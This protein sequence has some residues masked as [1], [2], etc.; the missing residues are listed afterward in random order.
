MEVPALTDLLPTL[1][2]A[3]TK[4]SRRLL[5]R[6]IAWG[7]ALPLVAACSP[8]TP[9]PAATRAPTRSAQAASPAASPA[10]KPSPAAGQV[11]TV[12]MTDTLKF[13]PA[14]LTVPRGATVTWQ[15]VG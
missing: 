4:V 10:A 8:A 14:A 9:A 3:R 5:L 15:T 13:E 11:F 2:A 7:A 12:N 1:P 6:T